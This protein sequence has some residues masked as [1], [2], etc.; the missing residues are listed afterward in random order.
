MNARRL[1]APARVE[2]PRPML[3]NDPPRKP[4]TEDD[5]LKLQAERED[6]T[7]QMIESARATLENPDSTKDAREIAREILRGFGEVA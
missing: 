6:R 7:Q 4:I 5:F 3:R 1:N 2:R